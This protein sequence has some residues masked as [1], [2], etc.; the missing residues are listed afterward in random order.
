MGQDEDHRVIL[1]R[2]RVSCESRSGTGT[3]RAASLRP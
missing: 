1:D 2:L 3:T